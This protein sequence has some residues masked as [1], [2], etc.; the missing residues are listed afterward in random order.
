[1]SRTVDIA[2]DDLESAFGWVSAAGPHENAAYISMAT[3]QIFYA[4]SM[5]DTEDELPAD[6]EDTSRYLSVPHQN[7]LDLGRS[8]AL[9]FAEERLSDSY[10]TVRE[11]FHHRGA[12]A[13]FKDLLERRGL[14]EHWYEYERKATEGALCAWAQDNGLT[15]VQGPLPTEA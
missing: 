13:R 11:F 2:Y 9:R 7:D 10:R 3:G 6:I 12:Y 1:M 8:L 5:S 15:V 14:L 4:S